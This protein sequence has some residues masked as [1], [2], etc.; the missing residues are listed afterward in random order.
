MNTENLAT[1]REN[2]KSINGF[3]NYEVSWWGRVRNAKTGR[4][5]KCNPLPSGYVNVS[6]SIEGKTRTYCIHQLVAREWV[7]NPNGK[8]CV[9]HIDGNKTNNHYENLRYATHS[10]NSMNQKNR[11]NTTS[12]YK[13]VSMHNQLRKWKVSIRLNGKDIYLGL[14]ENEREGAEAYNAMALELFGDF[15]KLNDF[16]D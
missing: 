6:L 9:D 16:D 3:V 11:A 8:R 4:I 14:F 15:A 5:L 2:W 10:E 7:L 13:G 1:N 12:I